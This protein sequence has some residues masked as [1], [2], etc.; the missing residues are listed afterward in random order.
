MVKPKTTKLAGL[1]GLA[2][3]FC[4]ASDPSAFAQGSGLIGARAAALA[5][6]P[7][8][9]APAIASSAELT[10]NGEAASLT[11]TLSAPVEASAFVLGEPDRVIVDLPSLAFQLDP[12]VGKPAKQPARHGAIP[13]RIVES[14][15]FGSFA[16]GRSRV[17]IDLGGPARVVRTETAKLA[18]RDGYRL[19]IQLAKTDR[20]AFHAAAQAS[21]VGDAGQ[22]GRR[23]D[24]QVVQDGR[25]RVT[26]RHPTVR[27][28]DRHALPSQSRSS[29]QIWGYSRLA[30]RRV[31]AV[32]QPVDVAAVGCVP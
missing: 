23:Q 22:F 18:D 6:K 7:P 26:E 2:F 9:A 30:R 32:P 28:G 11:F 25:G 19:T 8:V 16:P 31:H 21:R 27:E 10:D 12:Q 5:E 20:A 14:F 13:P 3:G 17:V 15:R 24:R 1:L 29:L 4:C